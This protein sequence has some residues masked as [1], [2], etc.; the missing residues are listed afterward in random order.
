MREATIHWLVSTWNPYQVVV[1]QTRLRVHAVRIGIGSRGPSEVDTRG[2][3]P[4]AVSSEGP[5][6]C[7]TLLHQFGWLSATA[8]VRPMLAPSACPSRCLSFARR[9]RAVSAATH[10]LQYSVIQFT[11]ARPLAVRPP[12]RLTL[13]RSSFRP[14]RHPS[15]FSWAKSPW[16][17]IAFRRC[18]TSE[19]GTKMA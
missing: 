6:V 4:S 2:R 7:C 10:I 18:R 17:Q 19:E 11:T 13:R 16:R 9:F 12:E 1:M 14:S 8:G 15:T 5:S 3:T